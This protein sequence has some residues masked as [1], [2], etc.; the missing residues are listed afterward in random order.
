MWSSPQVRQRKKHKFWIKKVWMI[1]KPLRSELFDQTVKPFEILANQLENQLKKIRTNSAHLLRN[2]TI[3]PN[4]Q[5][6]TIDCNLLPS[7]HLFHNSPFK[8]AYHSN[9]LLPTLLP[10]Q[11]SIDISP[12]THTIFQLKV[13]IRNFHLKFWR[14]INFRKNQSKFK[15][16]FLMVAPKWFPM[17]ERDRFLCKFHLNSKWANFALIA[18]AWVSLLLIFSASSVRTVE[19]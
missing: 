4:Q 18:S 17:N 7:A 16:K 1:W 8:F 9:R 5:I 10:F 12:T 6:D 11:L 3:P 15:N 19:L 2:W 13:S 14:R